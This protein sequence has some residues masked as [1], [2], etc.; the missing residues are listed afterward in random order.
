MKAACEDTMSVCP[1]QEFEVK[2]DHHRLAGEWGEGRRDD[3]DGVIH[4]NLV[5]NEYTHEAHLE[6]DLKHFFRYTFY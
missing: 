5:H 6:H 3:H 2:C 4:G 1:A